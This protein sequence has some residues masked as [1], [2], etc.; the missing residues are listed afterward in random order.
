M[1][2]LTIAMLAVIMTGSAFASTETFYNETHLWT[3]SYTSRAQAFEAGFDLLDQ[4]KVQ[5]SHK[6]TMALPVVETSARHLTI[7]SGEV[8]VEEFA[9]SRDT[10]RY[11]AV[12]DVNYHYRAH[13]SDN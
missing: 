12:V 5:P 13:V 2:K 10:V 6:L 9:D 8:T 7:D 3:D 4:L 1:K 11:R